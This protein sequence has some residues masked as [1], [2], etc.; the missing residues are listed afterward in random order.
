MATS[1]AALHPATHPAQ[2]HKPA[3]RSQID[4]VISRSVAIFGLIFGAQ[5][6]PAVFGQASQLSESWL[7]GFVVALFGGLLLAVVASV[8]QRFVRA[9]NI[10]IAVVYL[11]AMVTWPWGVLD[12]AATSAGRPWLWYLC[13]LATAAA[14]VALSTWMAT[15]YLIVAPLAYALIRVTPSGGGAQWQSALLDAVYAIILGGAV[16][17]L[18][19]LLRSAAASL[20]AAQTTA[21]A[22]YSHAVRQHATEVERV[23]VDSI[24]HDSVLTTLLSAASAY[25]A[26]SKA[27]AGRMA[28]QAIGHLKDAAAVA[29][30]DAA[31]V[32]LSQVATRII[33]ATATLSAPFALHS[34]PVAEGGIPVQAADAVYSASVQ[35]MVNSLQH[36]GSAPSIERWL[37]V[38]GTGTG[39]LEVQVG[40]TGVGFDPDDVQVGRLGLRVSILERVTNA[41]GSVR[42]DSSPGA[43][44]IITILWPATDAV[45]A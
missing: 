40:D 1:P 34:Q 19:T 16:L 12:V 42:I 18:M 24:V 44:T 45:S 11:I 23:Q 35:A 3:S 6:V 2:S 4:I 25:D 10:Y 39:G 29:P 7:F 28:E 17:I 21:L 27:L 33:G 22:R 37:S 13:T 38:S 31:S 41:G 20:D 43:G 14:A 15:L 30:D 32:A 9:V 8:V 5:T 26:D 36:A